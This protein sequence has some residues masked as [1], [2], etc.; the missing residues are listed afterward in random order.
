MS[1]QLPGYN[2]T[3]YNGVNALNPPNVWLRTRAPIN[4]Q[5]VNNYR[6]GDE[7]LWSETGEAWKLTSVT[8]QVGGGKLANWVSI[9]GGGASPG[10]QALL[11][12][13]AVSVPPSGGIVTLAGT[14]SQGISTSGNVNGTATLNVQNADTAGNK[15]VSTYDPAFFTAV[16]G[17]VDPT[18]ATTGATQGVANFDSNQF[19]VSGGTVSLTGSN[20]QLPAFSYAASLQSNVTGSGN[21]YTI[22]FANRIIDQLASFDGVSTFTAPFDGLYLLGCTL[23][24][25]ASPFVVGNNGLDLYLNTTSKTYTFDTCNVYNCSSNV[26]FYKSSNSQLVPMSAGDTATMS[27]FVAGVANTVSIQDNYCTFWGYQVA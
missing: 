2:T 26:N 16:N 13:N 3:A 8:N 23:S 4:A 27:L 6:L 17:L 10:I 5:D 9:T 12:D 15:G 1:S 24:I 18:L 11:C 25:T 7:W 21:S 14:A 20:G 22:I 19:S